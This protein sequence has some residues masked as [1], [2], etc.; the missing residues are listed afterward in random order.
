MLKVISLSGILG[1]AAEVVKELFLSVIFKCGSIA[2]TTDI[3]DCFNQV[4][5]VDNCHPDPIDS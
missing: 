2:K 4:E 1:E 5:G 3:S